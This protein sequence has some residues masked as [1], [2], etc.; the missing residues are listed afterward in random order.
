[1]FYNLVV[2]L[3]EIA[4]AIGHAF[5]W[6]LGYLSTLIYNLIIV[7]YNLFEYL[8]R[9]EIIN[10]S[11]VQEIY[12]KVGF[13]L[14]LFMLF[15]LIFSLVQALIDP[16]KLNDKKNGYAKILIRCVLSII[17][18]G[19]TPTIF[20]EAYQIQN[21]L[22]GSNDNSDNVLYKL[23]IGSSDTGTNSFGRTIATETYFAFYRDDEY[24]F[25]PN[26]QDTTDN[27]QYV[28]SKI[29]EIKLKI[30][31][32]NENFDYAQQYLNYDYN[33]N[34]T[35]EFNEL[36][37]VTF[38]VA[39]LWM[40]VVYCIQVAVRVFQLAYLQIIAPV[41]ILSY[42]SDPEGA[43]Q[44]WIKQCIS[45]FLDLFMRLAIIYFVIYFANHI[46][47]LFNDNESILI[48]STGLSPDNK[49]MWFLLEAF[50]I[51]GLLFFAK[52]FPD[53]IKDLFP[54]FGGGG[55]GK[56]SF[57]LN[58]KKEII[59]PLKW[60]YKSTPLGWA[61]R[62]LG[63]TGKKAIGAIDRKVHHVPKPRGKFGQYID[64][65]APERAKD[66]AANR[67]AKID[68][69]LRER[70]DLHGEQI[71]ES[72]TYIDKKTGERKFD[73]YKAFTGSGSSEYIASYNAVKSTKKQMKNAE[74]LVNEIDKE[75]AAAYNMAPGVERDNAIELA[76]RRRDAA[77]KNYGA[78]EA[79][80]NLAKDQHDNMKKMSKY[81]KF[82]KVEDDYKYYTDRHSE[83]VDIPSANVSGDS[84]L[85]TNKQKPDGNDDF[86][87]MTWDDYVIMDD[88]VAKANMDVAN[89]VG[90]EPFTE[91]VTEAREQ[92]Q[93]LDY[94]RD[95][96]A[97]KM[98]EQEAS[99]SANGVTTTETV[100]KKEVSTDN[101]VDT[102][103]SKSELRKVKDRLEKRY[104]EL[105]R[106]YRIL[107]NK[108]MN[109]QAVDTAEFSKIK[110]ERQA[111]NKELEKV[112]TALNK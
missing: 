112:Y 75:L 1:M 76:K 94:E 42:I 12:R 39:I 44:K 29:E 49:G 93:K 14:G 58:P 6:L 63:W 89:A 18:L 4:D 37:S 109:G 68:A 81:S 106:Q 22:I 105:D 50:L 110:A 24:P 91:K 26:N 65:L 25:L 103:V 57:G 32:G 100:D 79:R 15:K 69:N 74:T 35:V 45:T 61:P 43:F 87:Q 27:S 48:N 84:Q 52:K 95:A 38:G 36:L 23:I 108:S 9:A 60:G 85:N 19:I 97:E 8:A 64:K 92:F 3:D 31:S 21:L 51:L 78:Y 30:R 98:E 28:D 62:A 83:F 59:D 53:L 67:Q 66:V 16:D 2:S 54:N 55:A 101:V 99:N 56:F 86:G 11:F 5:R 77:V 34:Y 73:P 13:L 96:A 40:L 82:A 70:R 111:I 46:I 10:N 33:G 41:P 72:A 90:K 88:K 71:Y 104:R 80:Y 7:V 20:K 102:N 17:L 47:I 107:E